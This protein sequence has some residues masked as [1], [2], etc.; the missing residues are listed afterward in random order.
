[1]RWSG[2]RRKASRVALD[3]STPDLPLRPSLPLRPQWRATR[4]TTD[5][6]KVDVEIVADDVPAGIGGNA[7]QQAA[8][9]PCEVILRP[10]IADHAFDRAGGDVEGGDQGL[11]TMAAVLELTP[12]D[13][14]RHHRQPGRNALQGLNA[15]HLVDG[16]RA[17]SVIGGSRSLVNRADVGA[18]GI[19]G[20]IGLRGQPVTDAMRFEVG[21]FFRK[22]APLSAARCSAPSRVGWLRRQSRA[23]SKG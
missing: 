3:A 5:W 13:L 23:G 15:G 20:G 14:A 18:L 9:K 12:L 19:E 6:E 7:A 22:N 8:E 4:R 1:M 11:S 2:W 10:G 16:N 21:F 17:T